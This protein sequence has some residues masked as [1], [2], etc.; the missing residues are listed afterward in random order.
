MSRQRGH[1]HPHG[2]MHAGESSVTK[3]SEALRILDER[4]A[5]GEIDAEEF[6]KR[7]ELLKSSS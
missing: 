1:G 4:F 6:T 3:S 2:V 7:R 5:R